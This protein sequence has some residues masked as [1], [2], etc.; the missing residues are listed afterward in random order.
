[1]YLHVYMQSTS[2]SR[3]QSS[4]KWA[5][6]VECVGVCARAIN[7]I[8]LGVGKHKREPQQS[9]E[10]VNGSAPSPLARGVQVYTLGCV[11]LPRIGDASNSIASSTASV[12]PSDPT[13]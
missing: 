12:F 9:C 13:A 2:C 8:I 5:E 4:L 6:H 11:S 1:M 3:G 7:Y 10:S